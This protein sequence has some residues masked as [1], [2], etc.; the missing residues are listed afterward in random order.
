MTDHD[1]LWP[2][3]VAAM[4]G[5]SRPDTVRTY[6]NWTQRKANAGTPLVVADFPLPH[7]RVPRKVTTRG[8]H[9]RTIVS[10]RWHAHRPCRAC[11]ARGDAGAIDVYLAHKRGPGGR[12]AQRAS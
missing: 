4:L 10:P 6:A 9:E 11:K 1:L 2:E 8:G 7:D 12:P 3:Q 5:H